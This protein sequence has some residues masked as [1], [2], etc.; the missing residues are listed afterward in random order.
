[1]EKARQQINV[2]E[3]SDSL[4]SSTLTNIIKDKLLAG[5]S[6]LVVNYPRQLKLNCQAFL[7]SSHLTLLTPYLQASII[8][9]ASQ[10]VVIT[11]CYRTR[12]N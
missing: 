4:N 3:P 7:D 11:R 9:P 1:M 8:C 10:Q 2:T 12:I 5:C 6:I